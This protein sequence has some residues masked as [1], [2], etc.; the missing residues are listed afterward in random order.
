M[1]DKTNQEII[2]ETKET[3]FNVIKAAVPGPFGTKVWTDVATFDTDSEDA[4]KFIL[5]FN[6]EAV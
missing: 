5:K 4:S 6:E 2:R 1:A 3:V